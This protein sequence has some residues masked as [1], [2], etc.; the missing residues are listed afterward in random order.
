MKCPVNA[1]W[2]KILSDAGAV[3]ISV[4]LVGLQTPSMRDCD[5]FVA[6]LSAALTVV[7]KA[8]NPKD[9]S[10]GIG[11]QAPSESPTEPS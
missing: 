9:Q 5:A 3:F 1:K 8:A 4:F 6:A 11:A 2:R 10:Y 7:L